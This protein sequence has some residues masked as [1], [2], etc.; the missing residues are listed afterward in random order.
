MLSNYKHGYIIHT[1]TDKASKDTVVNRALSSLPGGPLEMTHTGLS[2][3]MTRTV[4]SLE[5]TRTVLSISRHH[6]SN[7]LIFPHI[8]R[9]L[10]Q[11]IEELHEPLHKH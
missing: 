10:F 8:H 3:E 6:I 5:M 1:L 7:K 11:K 2:L 9:F 4:L